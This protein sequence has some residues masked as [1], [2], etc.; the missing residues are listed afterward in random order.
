MKKLAFFLDFDGTIATADVVDAVLE[1]FGAPQWRAV[2][3]D[4]ADG[5]IGSRE[6]LSRQVALVRADQAAVEALIDTI[7]IDPGFESFLLAARKQ[8]VPVAI[9]SDGFDLFIRRI[10]DR[11]VRDRS[12]LSDVPVFSNKLVWNEGRLE[13]SFASTGCGHGCAN[14]KPAV[15][16]ERRGA[17][18][19]AAFVGDGLSD[20]FAARSAELVFAKAK[21]LDHC[22][23]NQIRCRPYEGFAEIEAWLETYAK[24]RFAIEFL[25]QNS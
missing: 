5:K 24:S 11:A 21:L 9:V 1:R 8:R 15:I 20:R 13:A 19:F 22:K 6:C 14:C 7:G 23:K 3:K 18:G 10:L 17:D 4:W 12:L 25:H 16:A 2:E